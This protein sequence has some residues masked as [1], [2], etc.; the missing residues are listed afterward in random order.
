MVSSK[1]AYP[2]N[3]QKTPSVCKKPPGVPPLPPPGSGC[4]D[5]LPDLL[6]WFLSWDMTLPE[7]HALYVSH[8]TAVFNGFDSWVGQA[9]DIVPIGL[10]FYNFKSIVD[11]TWHPGACDQQIALQGLYENNFPWAFASRTN[12]YDG[13]TPWHIL[14]LNLP[15]VL[16]P[17]HVDVLGTL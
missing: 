3:L 15:S 7:G 16:H 9:T 17:G 1:F 14:E 5:L 8:V 12:T 11:Y 13:G 2:A 10:V 4:P 6:E